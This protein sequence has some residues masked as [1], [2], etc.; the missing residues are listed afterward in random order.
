MTTMVLEA[1]SVDGFADPARIENIPPQRPDLAEAEPV[2]AGTRCKI[3][4]LEGASASKSKPGDVSAARACSS[5]CLL[6]SRVV[7][8]AGSLFEGNVLKN[9][10]PRWLSRAGSLY[11]AFTRLLL[12]RR[13]SLPNRRIAR[14]GGVGSEIAHYALMPKGSL[15]GERPGKAWMAINLGVTAGI[16]KEADDTI[17]LI[18]EAHR[19]DARPTF[20]RP[21]PDE[22]LPGV[23]LGLYM[24]DA[25]R[26]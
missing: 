25:S 21:G 20:P 5:R 6:N 11:L 15:H 10:P 24:V 2:P 14:R 7:L 19:F 18:I 13:Q 17:Q 1:S 8:P 16:A 22:S 23:R 4:L 26:A 9:T 12:A 3:L